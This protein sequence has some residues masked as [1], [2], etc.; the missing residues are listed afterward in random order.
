[1]DK[2][3]I[4]KKKIKD[5]SKYSGVVWPYNPYAKSQVPGAYLIATSPTV[6][7]GNSKV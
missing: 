7:G 4:L 6:P 2:K 1:M 5:S 3:T